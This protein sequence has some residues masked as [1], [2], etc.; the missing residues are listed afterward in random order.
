M[1]PIDMK[2]VIRKYYELN[3]AKK[4]DKLKCIHGKTPFTKTDSSRFPRWHDGKDFTCQS[5]R[6][7]RCRFDPWVRKIS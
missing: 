2:K 1:Y 3:D 4:F 6:H 5:R 7:K